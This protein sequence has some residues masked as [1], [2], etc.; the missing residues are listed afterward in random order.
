MVFQYTPFM[1]QQ[2]RK[3][4][5]E[6]N[7]WETYAPWSLGVTEATADFIPITITSNECL[8]YCKLVTEI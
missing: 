4:K 7:I 5:Q 2:D 8:K 6:I 3:K 1:T